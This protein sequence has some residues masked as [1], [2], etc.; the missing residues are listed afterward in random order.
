MTTEIPS[1]LADS[2]KT[3]V[4][5]VSVGLDL[6]LC[7]HATYV[8]SL[9]GRAYPLQALQACGRSKLAPVLP[10]D[11]RRRRVEGYP[12]CPKWSATANDEGVIHLPKQRSSPPINAIVESMTHSFSCFSALKSYKS[13][14]L[15]QINSNLH[16]PNRMYQPENVMAS[17]EP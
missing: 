7:L 11:R 12:T 4:V 2:L 17:A 13:T 16:V 1:R 8:E 14:G 6:D 15:E 10:Q 9:L 5:P 3:N